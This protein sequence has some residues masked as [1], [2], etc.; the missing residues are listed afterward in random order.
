[1]I[2][3][4]IGVSQ[5]GQLRRDCDAADDGTKRDLSVSSVMLRLNCLRRKNGGG[6]GGELERLAFAQGVMTD[7]GD[8]KDDLPRC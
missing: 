2:D 7:E 5:S 1:M 8:E 6:R 4:T 3:P